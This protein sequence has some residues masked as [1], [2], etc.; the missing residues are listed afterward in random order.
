VS[1]LGKRR[2]TFRPPWWATALLVT[3]ILVCV[4]LGRWQLDRAAEKRALFAGFSAGAERPP[5]QALPDAATAADER[6]RRIRLRGRYVPD[7]QLLLDNM[8]HEGR[9]GYHVL[10]PLRTEDVTVLV[11]RGWIPA[12][13]RRD[14]L[15]DVTVD[16]SPR[17]VAGQLDRLPRPGLELPSEPAVPGAPWPRRLLFP[18]TGTI[19]EQLG[20]PVAALQVLLDADAPDG[21]LRDWRP[22]VSGP[23]MHIGYAVQWFAFAAA[24]GAIYL[25]LNVKR[26]DRLEHG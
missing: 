12:P 16:A 4:A 10:T 8:I 26:H 13:P 17:E 20:E 3:G 21:Y 2:L 14:V 22:N 18:S 25:I 5:L 24:M 11:N 1:G 6:Y 15:P 19:A 7:R 23:N 9:V